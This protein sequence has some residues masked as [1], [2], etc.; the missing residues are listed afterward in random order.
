MLISIDRKYIYSDKP[1]YIVVNTEWDAYEGYGGR[2][3]VE[4]SG[5]N[6]ITKGVK[7]ILIY[8]IQNGVLGHKNPA[9]E[10]V[11]RPYKIGDK[12]FNCRKL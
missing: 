12:N 3:V 9:Y 6:E 11:N 4:V 5:I 10:W 2:W 7:A 1:P 8:Q